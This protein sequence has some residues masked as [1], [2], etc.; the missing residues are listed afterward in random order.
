MKGGITKKALEQGGQSRYQTPVERICKECE[1]PCLRCHGQADTCTACTAD[2]LL[3]K[4]TCIDHCPDK[5]WNETV[6]GRDNE[7]VNQCV[8]VG[9]ICPEG[10]H[11]ND[12]GE[13]CVPNEFECKD[14]YEI[15]E[16][17][18][19][20]IPAP[21]SPVPFPFLFTAIC[22]G[23]VVAGSYMKEKEGTKIFTCLVFL[24]SSMELLEYLLIAIFA[25]L[26]EE[27][28]A[29]LLAFVAVSVL[30]A[31]NIVFSIGYR[32]YTMNDRG[33]ADWI[34]LFP[35]TRMLVPIVCTLVNF[36]SVR[37][38]FSGF[39]GLENCLA[40]FH[41]PRTSVHK[42]LQTLTYVK[43]VFVYI[44]IFLADLIIF[45]AV[46]WGHQLLILAIETFLL[47]LFMIF[48]TYKEFQDPARLYA[49]AEGEYSQLKPRKNGQIAVMG[50]FEDDGMDETHLVR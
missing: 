18:T 15:N 28:F 14:G 35:K 24:I 36:T 32:K 27:V 39:F 38:V 16:K 40:T 25:A 9:L 20:C 11:V 19:A 10:F 49:D 5:Y 17:R 2:F 23:L 37:F 44:P 13:G 45:F 22:M 3:Y 48:L 1:V 7:P 43:Y 50:A 6:I 26:L 31:S 41:E 33:Y 34:R 21:G 46:G 12:A 47:Q 29:S 42:H 8:L 4:G 30:V